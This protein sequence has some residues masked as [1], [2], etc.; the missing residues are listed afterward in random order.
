V[1]VTD[2]GLVECTTC[3][4]YRNRHANELA[5][6]P[7]LSHR[8]DDIDAMPSR[9]PT[10]AAEKAKALEGVQRELSG[11]GPLV[12]TE[13]PRSA[14]IRADYADVIAANPQ[15][16]S[17]IEAILARHADDPVKQA[18]GLAR[19]ELSMKTTRDSPQIHN[20]VGT[21]GGH[22]DE[23]MNTV[24]T[25][26]ESHHGVM[27]EWM[28]QNTPGYTKR[29]GATINLSAEGHNTT[30][31]VYNEWL[32]NLPKKPGGSGRSVDWTEVPE[33]DMRKMA[34]EMMQR[35]GVPRDK[36]IEFFAKY[37]DQQKLAAVLAS[38]A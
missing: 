32:P 24:A 23:G 31:A 34:A 8:L 27:N 7:E 30:K 28:E 10:E 18:K 35:A 38:A 9:T 25:G 36:R 14:Q 4:I 29:D 12:F 6:N 37:D 3:D 20:N 21:Y 16:G 19:L 33:S 2:H 13:T 17:E 1:K 15:F 11:R 5:A 22:I 26:H